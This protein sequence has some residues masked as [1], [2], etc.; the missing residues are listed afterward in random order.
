MSRRSSFPLPH[1]L[2]DLA[3]DTAAMELCFPSAL[4]VVAPGGSDGDAKAP[5]DAKARRRSD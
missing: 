2:P 3:V 4:A 5:G 1:P